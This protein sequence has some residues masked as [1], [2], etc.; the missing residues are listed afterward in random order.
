LRITP[1][2]VHSVEDVERLIGALE[3]LWAQCQLA[4]LP[5]AAQ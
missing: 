1:S 2:P 5:I 4:R 3:E